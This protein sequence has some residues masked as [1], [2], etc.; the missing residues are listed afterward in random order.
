M[1]LDEVSKI[2]EKYEQFDKISE[3]KEETE[4]NSYLMPRNIPDT[5]TNSVVSEVRGGAPAGVD[6][7]DP[8]ELVYRTNSAVRSE[9]WEDEDE[10]D[11]RIAV[12]HFS[13]SPA[14]SQ[15]G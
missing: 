13:F 8:D 14:K 4:I 3:E 6:A 1:R 7:V 11:Q 10:R 5:E 12:E 15:R 2:L 9:Y